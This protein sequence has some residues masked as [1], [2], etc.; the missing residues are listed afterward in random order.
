MKS[1][2]V[3][4]MLLVAVFDGGI[5]GQPGGDGVEARR[6]SSS[7]SGHE[8]AVVRQLVRTGEQ[9][10]AEKS[11]TP[12]KFPIL[13][14][15]SLLPS[16][17][18]PSVR[19]A[20]YNCSLN[21]SETGRLAR[22]LRGG[23]NEHGRKV[24]RIIQKIRPDVLLLNEFDYDE[25]GKALKS[26][27][28]EYLAVGE[29]DAKG[30]EYPFVFVAP[31][32][33]GVESGIDMNQDGKI[34]LPDDG[35][36]FGKHPGHYGMVVLSRYEIDDASVRTFQ[37]FLWKD[38]P[39]AMLPTDK[40]GQPCYDQAATSR[41]RLSS[42]SHWDVPLKIGDTVIH[43][44][45]CH[46]TPPVFD[47]PED[48]NGCRNHDEIR[49]WAEYIGD[50]DA[51]W[52]VDDAGKKGGLAADSR[53][54]IAGDLNADPNDGESTNSPARL[55]V[56]NPLLSDPL[57]TSPGGPEAAK[58]QLGANE[59]HTGPAEH[60]TGDFAD[61]SVGNLRV[62]Y[63]LPSANQ[64]VLGS[65]VFWPAAGEVDASLVD[66]SDHRLVWVDLEI[67]HP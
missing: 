48:R 49:F 5:A 4:G 10:L 47:G 64:T 63:V 62:D 54:V 26:F 67:R 30:I 22:D 31:V 33:T 46:P 2:V 45:V 32:N 8:D 7:R 36:G 39:D 15:L 50:P 56:E 16:S 57:P 59:K 24:A 51:D 43:F 11:A 3:L 13:Q 19:F 27:R 29:G 12:E 58:S 20:T 52:I 66:A 60:D 9:E 6:N 53:F 14:Q 18:P 37:N 17:A 25:Q 1:F 38:M 28:D 41:L 34:E 55:L 40:S 35:F 42:K 23:R 61:K 21:R 65:G 44:L